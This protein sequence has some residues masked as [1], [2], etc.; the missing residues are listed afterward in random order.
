[1]RRTRLFSLLVV[2]L[3]ACSSQPDVY[4]PP[5]QRKPQLGP[6]TGH[7]KHFIAMNDPYAEEHF[8][9][10]VRPLEAGYYRWTG[11]RPMFHFVL[12]TVRD[13]KLTMDFSVSS[14]TFKVTGP[15]TVEYYVNGRQLDKVVYDK[16]GEKHFEKPVPADWLVKGGDTVVSAELDKVYVAEDGVKLGV[17]LVRAG[18]KD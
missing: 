10:D 3:S 12:S 18:F 15:V 5:M 2:L 6:E 4:A 14:E 11:Q 16:P 17:T 1:M 7:L 13:L 9:R 8:L